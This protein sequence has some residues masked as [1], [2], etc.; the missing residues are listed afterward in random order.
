MVATSSSDAYLPIGAARHREKCDCMLKWRNRV[1]WAM[2]RLRRRD[3]HHALELVLS[4]FDLP[5]GDWRVLDKRAWRT[6]RAGIDEGWPRRAREARLITA[7]RS[8]EQGHGQRWL[9]AQATPL[10]SKA[11]AVKALKV[12]PDQ[13]LRNLRA[14]VTVTDGNDRDPPRLTGVTHAWAHEDSTVGARGDGVALY[15]AFVVDST[16]AAIAASGLVGS[17]SWDE[18]LVVAAQQADRLGDRS[19]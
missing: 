13:F 2:S 11:D 10:V 1:A 15:V 19:S 12:V 7:W 3:A 17:W 14:D 9:W 18:L 8:Y 5:G 4:P 6:G 16:L